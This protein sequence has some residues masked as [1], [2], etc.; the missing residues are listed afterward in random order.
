MKTLQELINKELEEFDKQTKEWSLD[1][2]TSTAIKQFLASSI[3][4]VARTVLEDSKLEKLKFQDAICL[5]THMG[6]DDS[7]NEGFNQA[8]VDQHSKINSILE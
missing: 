2:V 4:R 3:E 8:V 5:G 7:C 1:W 6:C